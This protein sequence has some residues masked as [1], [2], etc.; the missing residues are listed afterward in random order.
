MIRSRL[1][2]MSFR[3][4]ADSLLKCRERIVTGGKDGGPMTLMQID[5]YLEG[6]AEELNKE[7][8]KCG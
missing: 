2:A 6:L 4:I 5:K 1:E 3:A 7:A 8:G